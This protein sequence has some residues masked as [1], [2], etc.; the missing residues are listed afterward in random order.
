MKVKYGESTAL[1]MQNVYSHI[2]HQFSSFVTT[3]C[4]SMF[5]FVSG[6][7]V[8]TEV[9]LKPKALV[10]VGADELLVRI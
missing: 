4:N 1:L 8:F 3:Y 10:R 5:K 2:A 9:T 7:Q 6:P